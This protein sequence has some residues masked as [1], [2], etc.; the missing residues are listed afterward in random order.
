MGGNFELE[1]GVGEDEDTV[2]LCRCVC[3]CGWVCV[4]VCVCVVGGWVVVV[5]VE[6]G[7][8]GVRGADIGAPGPCGHEGV[9]AEH[10]DVLVEAGP[11][12][13]VALVFEGGPM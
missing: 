3:V 11:V 12:V 4:C 6:V 13:D 9:L 7:C 2:V 8:G 10:R 1:D 5:V